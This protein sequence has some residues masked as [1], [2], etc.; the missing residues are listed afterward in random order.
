M[1]LKSLYI[2]DY[3]ILKDFSIE[4]PY[5]FEK[6]IAVFIGANG[7][8]KSTILEA[9]A[10]IFSSA[11]MNETAKFEFELE[12]SVRLEQ[13][14]EQ[15]TTTMDVHTAYIIVKLSAYKDEEIKVSIVSGMDDTDYTDKI[16]DSK[17]QV[18]F[19]LGSEKSV[20]SYLPDNIIIYYSGLSQI[21]EELCIPHE[22]KLSKAYRKNVNLDRSFFYYSP[23]HF[24][25]ILL[26]LLSFEFGDIPEF[27]RTKA[28]ISG[29]QSIQIRL[30]KPEWG[31]KDSIE[32]F[33]GAEG[34]VRKLL[35]YLDSMSEVK[36][37]VDNLDDNNPNTN[38]VVIESF[39][40]ES[41][42]ITLLGL[43]ILYKTRE[44]LVEERNLFEVF[45][46]ML[47]DGLLDDISFSFIKSEHEV[48][49]NFSVLS[50]GEQQA[51]TIKGLT[52]L[53][54]GK[55][56]LFLFDEPDTYLHP[57]WQSQFLTT[58]ED[59]I[60]NSY[61]SENSF[62]IA[63]HSP[64]M[65]SNLRQGAIYKMALGVPF[66]YSGQTYGKDSNLILSQTMETVPRLQSIDDE[67][68][69]LD[70]LIK[71]GE[72]QSAK[73]KIASLTEILGV[74]DPTLIRLSAIIKRKEIIGR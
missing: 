25:I 63:T 38:G 18:V 49:C 16:I 58:I 61:E 70:E 32:N 45:N 34:E 69:D 52:E 48:H 29:V 17:K 21:M 43:D 57:E 35:N 62:L 27:L 44:F 6:Y 42:V 72:F 11:V 19:G 59:A 24:G 68:K 13:V 22:V 4:F 1:Q 9:I 47:A 20:Q 46:I 15:T 14:L 5:D 50:E 65:L 51:I 3:K 10:Q 36:G 40:N 30:K 71:K 66:K 60:A 33:W 67:I 53:L 31:D 64:M 28:K 12:Y 73:D 54:Y 74:S 23:E 7:S 39:Q 41:I 55:N 37:L 26:S 2:K 56:S 8:G